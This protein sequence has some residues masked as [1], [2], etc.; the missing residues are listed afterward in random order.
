MAFAN[1]QK[2]QV[3][4]TSE[5]PPARDAEVLS[6]AEVVVDVDAQAG[7][8]EAPNNQLTVTIFLLALCKGP[9]VLGIE[10]SPC[11]DVFHED[12]DGCI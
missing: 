5:P 6:V 8:G 3:P 11:T 4:S 2:N 12:T 10:P 1:G 7:R 9:R